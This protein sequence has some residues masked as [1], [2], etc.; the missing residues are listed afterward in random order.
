MDINKA[1]TMY[2]LSIFSDPD[3][4]ELIAPFKTM[5]E[6]RLV[7]LDYFIEEF[8]DERLDFTVFIKRYNGE[9]GVSVEKVKCMIC[10]DDDGETVKYSEDYGGGMTRYIDSNGEEIMFGDDTYDGIYQKVKE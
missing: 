9:G 2:I 5:K 8:P 6:L 1:F 10:L 7:A 4:P 3:T